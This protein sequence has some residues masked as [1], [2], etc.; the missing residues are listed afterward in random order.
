M[1]PRI[2]DG[3]DTTFP[4]ERYSK[5]RKVGKKMA[6]HI[7]IF[8]SH[9]TKTRQPPDLG[10]K[11]VKVSMDVDLSVHRGMRFGRDSLRV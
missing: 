6:P 1:R 7:L 4:V 3:L 10:V 9:L 2:F 8:F 5:I 11:V